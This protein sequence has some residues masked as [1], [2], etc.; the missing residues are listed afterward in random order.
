MSLKRFDTNGVIVNTMKANPSNE[1]F[2]VDGKIYYNNTPQQ[3]GA[4]SDSVLNVPSGH[5]SLYEYNVDRD[6]T[7]NPLSYP[8]VYRT[9]TGELLTSVSNADYYARFAVGDIISSSYPKS[10]SI[11]REYMVTAGQRNTGTDSETGATFDADPVYP[12]GS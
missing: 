4:F 3:S 12:H 9:G 2:V 5:I 7:T 6:S 8:F 11:T 1:F 10:A